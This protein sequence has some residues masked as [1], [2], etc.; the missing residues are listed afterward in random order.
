MKRRWW[1]VA[2]GVVIVAVVAAGLDEGIDDDQSATDELSVGVGS[3]VTESPTEERDVTSESPRTSAA[4]TP[5]TTLVTST[6]VPTTIDDVTVPT[7]STSP[8]FIDQTRQRLDALTI[9]DPDPAR[10]FYER[11][12]YGG[13]ADI[14][15][16]CQST[17]HEVLIDRSGVPVTFSANGCRVET[18]EWIDPFTGDVLTTADDAT[19]DHHV[20]LAEAHRAGAWR[21]N[22]D[23][24]ERFANDDT[25]GALNIVGQDVNQAKADQRPDQWLPPLEASHCAYAI[26]WIDTK[27]RWS[28]TATASEYDVLDEL[29]DSCDAQTIP[30]D[31]AFS[32]AVVVTTLAPTPTT[33]A[34][35]AVGSGPGDVR[36]ES[37]NKR[38]EEVVISNTGG[39]AADLGG[40]I[41]HDEGRKHETPLG[42]WGPLPAGSRLTI[43]T[44]DEATA[45]DGRVVWKRQNVWNNDG[46]IANLVGPDGTITTI[47][48]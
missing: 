32:E 43:V 17:R 41:L 6:V 38:S 16:D 27:A 37:C 8:A 48:C 19:I 29:L 2:G 9:A 25:A 10:R 34:P 35:V 44:G 21:W 45:G 5:S 7:A 22:D 20:P 40:F 1:A 42:Q 30:A 26:A 23:T 14:D 46:D 36:L 31:T 3:A 24:K 28:L 47:R 4:T 39:Q 18:G 15:G 13:W 33:L 12:E 11:D